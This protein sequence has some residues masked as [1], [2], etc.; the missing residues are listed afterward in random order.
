MTRTFTLTLAGLAGATAIGAA[1]A[2]ATFSEPRINTSDAPGLRSFVVTAPH[3]ADHNDGIV[4][5]MAWYPSLSDGRDRIV[6]ENPVFFGV[7]ASRDATFEA[8]ADGEAY[9]LVVL[10]HGLGGHHRSMSWLASEVASR[11]AIVI[12]ISHPNSSWGDF[13]IQAGMDHWTRAQDI[14]ATI[15]AA[16][17][18][19]DF[20]GHIDPDRIMVA[21][22]SYGGWTALSVG[23][24]LGDHAGY[25]AH[26]ADAQQ[27][28]THCTDLMEAN[29]TL[30]DMDP[31]Q[32]NG[33][34]ADPRVTH[35]T[36][37]DPALIWGMDASNVASLV[38]HVRLIALGDGPD[39][40]LATDF[41]ESGFAAL[42]PDAAINRFAPASHFMFL[43]L[44]KP[45]GA[46]ILEYENDDPVCTDP[47]GADRA[48]LHG[49]VIDLIADDLGL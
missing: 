10:S 48:A 25:V 4:E 3:H 22:F 20:A 9:P 14:Q 35:V 13:D 43:P 23:G 42:L 41:D 11:G 8:P 21:G 1:V 6:S 12:A 2:A 30:A 15:D 7:E 29:V 49:A 37:V 18:D 26:C 33:S 31:D 38:D 27:A 36:A 5:G 17:N 28:S 32:W 16:L 46:A 40:L 39:R 47:A 34:Y 44:C 45:E 19:A 24:V